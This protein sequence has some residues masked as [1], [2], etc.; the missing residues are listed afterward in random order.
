MVILNFDD[1]NVENYNKNQI[2][3]VLK[4][5]SNSFKKKRDKQPPC[6]AREK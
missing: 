5:I 4:I 3:A 6:L 2:L 1:T